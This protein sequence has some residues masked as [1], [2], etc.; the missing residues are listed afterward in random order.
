MMKQ[1]QTLM[2]FD[3]AFGTERPYPSHAQQYR[4][5][6]GKVAWLF[7]PWTGEKRHPADIGSDVTGLLIAPA[8]EPIYAATDCSEAYPNDW[9]RLSLMVGPSGEMHA[10]GG[11]RVPGDGDTPYVG[12]ERLKAARPNA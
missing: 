5:W 2:K 4:D 3:P 9:V 6:H 11:D 8:N 7:N 10:I 1:Q 12:L